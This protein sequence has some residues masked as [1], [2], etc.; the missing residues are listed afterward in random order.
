MQNGGLR[1]RVQH[2]THSRRHY[3]PCVCQG[4]SEGRSIRLAFGVL[5]EIQ[6]CLRL[7]SIP[8]CIEEKFSGLQAAYIGS[9]VILRTIRTL[10]AVETIMKQLPCS[11]ALVVCSPSIVEHAR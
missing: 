5:S 9:R 4:S 7:G 6:R 8:L 11:S 3:R 1:S 10:Q 2:Y